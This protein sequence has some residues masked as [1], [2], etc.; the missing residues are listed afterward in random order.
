M[1]PKKK[2]GQSVEASFFFFK[3]GRKMY[4]GEDMETKFG[5]DPLLP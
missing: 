4:I 5:A 2:D 1:N 3:E